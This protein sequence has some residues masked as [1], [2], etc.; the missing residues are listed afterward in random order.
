MK[1]TLNESNSHSW[2]GKYFNLK[3]EKKFIHITKDLTRDAEEAS[4]ILEDRIPELYTKFIF[5]GT[6]YTSI[7]EEELNSQLVEAFNKDTVKKRIARVDEF[8]NGHVMF[9]YFQIT[10]DEAEEQARQMSIKQPDKVFYVKYDNIMEPCSDIKWKNGEQISEAFMPVEYDEES[11]E[12]FNRPGNEFDRI[13]L[14]TQNLQEDTP[15]KNIYYHDDLGGIKRGNWLNVKNKDNR[16]YAKWNFEPDEDDKWT[17]VTDSIKELPYHNFV[18]ERPAKMFS[19]GGWRHWMDDEV[20]KFYDIEGNRIDK[21][22]EVPGMPRL[23]RESI[24]KPDYQLFYDR[25]LRL[26]TVYLIDAEGNQIS[27]TEYASNR[28]D[29]IDLTRDSNNFRLRESKG[30][31]TA[32]RIM[33]ADREDALKDIDNDDYRHLT[34]LMNKE[35]DE[36]KSKGIS[37]SEHKPSP[38]LK[39]EARTRGYAITKVRTKGAFPKVEEKLE[40]DE[41]EKLNENSDAKLDEDIEVPTLEGPNEGAE[42]G[43]SELLNSAIQHELAT[44]NEYNVLALNARAE[45]F[46]DLANVIDEINTEENKHIGQLQ[47]LLKTVS[48]NAQAIVA[49]ETEASDDLV[50]VDNNLE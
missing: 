32:K 20:E 39:K 37:W 21:D 33:Y 41:E 7:A 13:D 10:S 26:W 34:D 48:P 46:D 42:Y 9:D 14:Q 6:I 40:V 31:D 29:A 4:A 23:Q 35:V 43:L 45:G 49:G 18:G 11:G 44:V 5:G 25:H 16:T 24:E 50:Q 38:N 47:E 15:I 3:G 30:L 22:W 8:D 28:K 1:I 27:D 2:F 36:L 12:Y 17:D 19:F